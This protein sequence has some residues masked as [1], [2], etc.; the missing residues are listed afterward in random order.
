MDGKEEAV[1]KAPRYRATELGRTITKSWDWASTSKQQF[2][3]LIIVMGNDGGATRDELRDCMLDSAQSIANDIAK[4]PSCRC[5]PILAQPT[6]VM[7][8]RI[9]RDID[10]LLAFCLK[11]GWAEIVVE[12]T[13]AAKPVDVVDVGDEKA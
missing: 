7:H 11:K 2:L 13:A 5:D 10:R 12:A 4:G 8:Q 9:G 1:E 6:M 3:Q